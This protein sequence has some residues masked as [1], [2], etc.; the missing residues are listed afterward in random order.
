LPKSTT[1]I[2]AFLSQ[3]CSTN[4]IRGPQTSNTTS[5]DFR[6]FCKQKNK[7]VTQRRGRKMQLNLREKQTRLLQTCISSPL[8]KSSC[9]LIFTYARLVPTPHYSLYLISQT[10]QRKY[11]SN[12]KL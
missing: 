1:T 10:Y 2:I 9:K 6:S 3:K 4:I 12:T 7:W 8:Y 11:T 5:H